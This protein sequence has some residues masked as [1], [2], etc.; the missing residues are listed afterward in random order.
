VAFCDAVDDVL[1]SEAHL[2]RVFRCLDDVDDLERCSRMRRAWRT[3]ALAAARALC[4]ARFPAAAAALGALSPPLPPVAYLAAARALARASTRLQRVEPSL[5]DALDDLWLLVEAHLPSEHGCPGRCVFANMYTLSTDDDDDAA[6]HDAQHPVELVSA[7][8]WTPCATDD[9][10][11]VP[12]L[13]PPAAAGGDDH[14]PDVG[15]LTLSVSLLRC[16]TLELAPLFRRVRPREVVHVSHGDA[17]DGDSHATRLGLHFMC[18]AGTAGA[19]RHGAQRQ[20]ACF[21]DAAGD[22]CF[23]GISVVLTPQQPSGTAAATTVLQM[24]SADLLAVRCSAERLVNALTAP[25][26]LSCVAALDWEPIARD[27]IA[28][29][30]SSDGAAALLAARCAHPGLSDAALVDRHWPAHGAA[31]RALVAAGSA[32][33]VLGA[34]AAAQAAA[35]AESDDAR[36]ARLHGDDAAAPL[37]LLLQLHE[38]ADDDDADADDV[39]PS[40]LPPPLFSG[41]AR[42][43]RCDDAACVLPH[44]ECADAPHAADAPRAMLRVQLEQRSVAFVAACAADDADAAPPRGPVAPYAYMWLLRA[45]PDGRVQLARL[46]ARVRPVCFAAAANATG[47]S[48]ALLPRGADAPEALCAHGRLR[49]PAYVLLNSAA[50]RRLRISTVDDDSASDDS[51]DDDDTGGY[52][53]A[54]LAADVELTF[55]AARAHGCLP[56]GVATYALTGFHEW[57]HGMMLLDN[58]GA[59]NEA[60]TELP[61]LLPLTWPL[62]HAATARMDW[63]TLVPRRSESSCG[64][65]ELF[66]RLRLSRHGSDASG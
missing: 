37:W 21:A 8:E 9:A 18:A 57:A 49:T 26:L 7:S 3:A 17:G 44:F 27:G 36:W 20:T 66:A 52:R 5:R 30:S 34:F 60:G 63:Q 29:S 53:T 10:P 25:E 35:D 19:L 23:F 40:S 59:A 14:A 43:T 31:L 64:S 16:S 32:A 51:D 45:Q 38:D 56:P 12:P 28:A 54:I 33:S 1:S 47:V 50:R 24:H 13:P 65:A 2:L 61:R 46:A 55:S 6:D 15:G 62:L 4:V 39:A 58:I 42:I 22:P 41:A 48:V 11:P